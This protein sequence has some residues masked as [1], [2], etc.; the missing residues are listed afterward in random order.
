MTDSSEEEDLSRFQEA[1][2]DSFIQ[3]IIANHDD[4]FG[5]VSKETDQ[6]PRSQRYLEEAT[7]YNDVKVSK[8]L[9]KKIGAKVSEIINRNL[10]FVNVQDADIENQTVQGG[11][12]LFRD[13]V[14]FLTC[15]EAKDT[16]TEEHN[17]L[18]RRIRNKKFHSYKNID[19]MDE[20]AKLNSVAVSG[21]YILSKEETKFWKSRRKEKSTA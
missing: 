19:A 7:H 10:K 4:K 8:D 13:S 18:S 1:V 6:T 16:L 14:G 21:D 17:N 9:Q 15:E 3:K 20:A 12:K 11:V 5:L 2:D